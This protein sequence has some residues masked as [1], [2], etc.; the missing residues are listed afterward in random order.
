MNELKGFNYDEKAD[1]IY[2]FARKG[3]EE[4]FVEVVPGVNV[5]LGED[6]K[7][8]GIEILNAS[9]LL[10]LLAEKGKI[11]DAEGAYIGDK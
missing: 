9:R 8:I 4:E 7:I 11:V 10:K 6:G 2:I 5:E 1:A 3:V